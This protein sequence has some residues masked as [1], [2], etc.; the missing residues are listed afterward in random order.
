MTTKNHVV[1]D[2][3][4]KNGDP[5]YQVS[6]YELDLEYGSQSIGCPGRRRSRR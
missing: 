1:D 6:R 4:P 5:G 2:Y 3:L